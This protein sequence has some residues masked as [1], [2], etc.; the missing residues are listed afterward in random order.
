M[1]G[2][3][4]WDKAG[5]GFFGGGGPTFVGVHRT[6]GAQVGKLGAQWGDS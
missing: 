6:E 2:T 1:W 3:W 4:G 5:E